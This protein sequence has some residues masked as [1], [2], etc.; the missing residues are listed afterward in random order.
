MLDNND[1]AVKQIDLY[2]GMVDVF[3]K[4]EQKIIELNQ[5]FI[6]KFYFLKRYY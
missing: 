6:F 1:I 3:S 4:N 5:Q 2:Q